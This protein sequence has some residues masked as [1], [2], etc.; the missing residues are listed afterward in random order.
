M[1]GGLS[2]LDPPYGPWPQRGS[3]FKTFLFN[4]ESTNHETQSGECYFASSLET[5]GSIN[6]TAVLFFFLF[7]TLYINL[8]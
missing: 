5:D 1:K 4:Y 7:Y 8:L 2:D 6:F 3:M